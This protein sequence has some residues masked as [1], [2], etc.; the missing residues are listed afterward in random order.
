[1]TKLHEIQVEI[2]ASLSIDIALTQEVPEAVGYSYEVRPA[3]TGVRQ[4]ECWSWWPNFTE[5]L[6]LG[7]LSVLASSAFPQMQHW[8]TQV[9]WY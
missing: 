5:E 4:Q 6:A 7:E 9:C 1:M 8:L 2:Q 3:W